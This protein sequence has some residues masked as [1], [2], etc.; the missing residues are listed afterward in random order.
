MVFAS[1][2]AEAPDAGSTTS[3]DADLG[4][5]T[6]K[7]AARPLPSYANDLTGVQPFLS[8]RTRQRSGSGRC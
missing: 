2:D 8:T 3:Y 7:G 5:R 4:E 1:V 6:G